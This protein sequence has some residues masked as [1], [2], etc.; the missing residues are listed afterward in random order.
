MR[1]QLINCSEC[2]A[3]IEISE[4]LTL[5]IESDIRSQLEEEWSD[6]ESKFRQR[7]ES[8][9]QHE[10]SLKERESNLED[11][12][13][14]RLKSDRKEIEERAR[15]KADEQYAEA[16][17]VLTDELEEKRGL[18][19]QAQKDALQLQ[20]KQRKLEEQQEGLELEIEKR[21][22][23]E[24]KTIRAE[25]LKQANEGQ[26][27]KM[28]EKQDLINTLRERI[29][30]LQL[31]MEQGSQ[32]RQGE[33]MEGEL[34]DR[35]ERMFPFDSIDEIAQGR[36]GADLLH[37]VR[38]S[39]GKPCGSILWESKN[40]KDFSRKWIQ[41]LKEDQQ[42]A[43]ADIAAIVSV[44]RPATGDQLQFTEDIWIADFTCFAPLAE[45]LR[46]TLVYMDRE[47]VISEQRD[48]VKDL[49]YDYFTGPDFARRVK[50]AISTHVQMQKDLESE[51]R[52][53]QRIWKKRET[54]VRLAIE[55]TSEMFG[56]I[57]GLV[58]E[59][60]QLPAVEVL[61]LENAASL[62]VPD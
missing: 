48:S 50:R 14:D 18:L 26:V 58:S 62:S 7:Q 1:N 35:L 10:L 52:S 29:Q 33:A 28:R 34:K 37:T 9:N 5:K 13:E 3:E 21:L 61:Q 16:N 27:L 32:E 55:N 41:K 42:Q 2:G 39:S 57:E 31:R 8:I 30:D 24:R 4:L 59:Q 54:Q 20:R 15:K 49:V 38:N 23:K 46:N 53:L 17:L 45:M 22:N 11:L 56:E 44:A 43:S 36:R 51:K 19:K 47:S 25:A 60:K 6:K 40:T 12:I